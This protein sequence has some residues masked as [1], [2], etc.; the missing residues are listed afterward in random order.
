MFSQIKSNVC[1]IYKI[2]HVESGR[3]Y[4]GSSKDIRNRVRKH[5]EA[6]LRGKHHSKYLQRVFN[7]YGESSL[8]VKIMLVCGEHNLQMY[9]QILLDGFLPE[10]NGTKSA[11]SPVHRGQQLSAEWKENVAK[12]VRKRYADG[13]KIVHPPRSS[14]YRLQVSEQSKKNWEDTGLRRKMTEGIR[15]SMTAEERKNRSE[16]T[17][18]LWAD[19]EYRKKA[20]ES[21]KGK[22]YSKG[23]K[24]TPEQVLNRKKAGRISNMKRIHGEQWKE[25][26]VV[27]Y[28]EFKGDV[29]VQ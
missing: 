26:Y 15:G 11:N 24:C 23:Y 27:R 17:K 16:R 22:G 8:E 12:A 18:A 1:G 28:P 13:F 20:I 2:A 29:D 6:L 21:R 4:I 10:F 7:K 19:P 3:V 5:R 9:E 25:M 14:E